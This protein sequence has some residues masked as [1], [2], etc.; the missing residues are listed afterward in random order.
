[1]AGQS[2]DP[3]HD[4]TINYTSMSAWLVAMYRE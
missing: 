1:M 3:A 2:A 4:R